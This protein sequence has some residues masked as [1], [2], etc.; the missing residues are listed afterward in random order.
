MEKKMR[1]IYPGLRE[2]VLTNIE[3]KNFENNGKVKKQYIPIKFSAEI[4]QNS[5]ISPSITIRY[6]Y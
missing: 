4:P 2:I 3:I 5:Q 1:V 6:S